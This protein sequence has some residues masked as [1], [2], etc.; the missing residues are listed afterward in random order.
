M[1]SLFFILFFCFIIVIFGSAA[2]A[3][4]KAAPWVPTRQKDIK[5]MLELAEIKSPDLVY[6]LGAG[7][8]RLVLAVARNFPAKVVGFE[9]SVLPYLVARVKLLLA[10]FGTRTKI[11]YRDFYHFN[12]SEAD[13]ILCFLTPKAMCRLRPK[14]NRE[15]KSGARIVT[16]AFK[17]KDWPNVKISKPTPK[18]TP[19]FLHVKE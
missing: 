11:L 12:L 10:G 9:F 7:D 14:F 4:M 5:R 16:Y 13:V 6:D 1:D 8:G 15:L 18:D 3:G 19:I 2:W 17:I